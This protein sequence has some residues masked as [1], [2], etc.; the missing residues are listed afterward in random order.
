MEMPEDNPVWE[1]VVR[2]LR[3]IEE[4]R[5]CLVISHEEFAAVPAS[6]GLGVPAVFLTDWFMPEGFAQM[7]ALR[8]ADE[9]IFLE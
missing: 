6:K 1:T 9:V 2:S 5:P 8:Y 7:Q 4:H 3:V